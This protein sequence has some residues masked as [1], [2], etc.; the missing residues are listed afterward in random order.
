MLIVYIVPVKVPNQFKVMV[1]ILP[2]SDTLHTVQGILVLPTY[3]DH[4]INYSPEEVGF[5]DG[6][7]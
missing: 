7:L 5:F 1:N 4:F 2:E 3:S 6:L